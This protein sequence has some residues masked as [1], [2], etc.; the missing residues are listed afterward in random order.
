MP[1]EFVSL[2]ITG[3]VCGHYV[4]TVIDHFSKHIELYCVKNIQAATIA[5]C[6]LKYVCIF[7]RPS[8][9]FTGLGHSSQR[10]FSK[11]LTLH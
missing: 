10:K 7:G 3:P 4:L 8:F 1:G 9:V 11:I 6:F 5:K 2:D